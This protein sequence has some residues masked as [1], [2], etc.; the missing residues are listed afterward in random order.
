MRRGFWKRYDRRSSG[1]EWGGIS[2]GAGGKEGSR[3]GA[4]RSFIFWEIG[5][6]TGK[7]HGTAAPGQILA[8]GSFSAYTRPLVA[9]VDTPER[10]P[11]RADENRAGRSY[12]RKKAMDFGRA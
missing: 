10:G 9:S 3:P 6:E 11:H 7:T 4:F 5:A 2:D 1:W 12:K 8:L